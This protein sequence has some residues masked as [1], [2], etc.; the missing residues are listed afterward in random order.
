MFTGFFQWPSIFLAYQCVISQVRCIHSHWWCCYRHKSY[1]HPLPEWWLSLLHPCW[2]KWLPTVHSPTMN[3]V[4]WE[5]P[6]SIPPVPFS[7]QVESLIFCEVI[8]ICTYSN[9]IVI[10]VSP[11]F[12]PNYSILVNSVKV[13]LFVFVF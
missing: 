7:H 13:Y 11:F 10:L 6:E 12:Q 9:I 5:S 1:N 3:G 4:R 2:L 8:L